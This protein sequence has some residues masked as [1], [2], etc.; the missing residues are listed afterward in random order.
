VAWQVGTGQANPLT[1]RAIAMLTSTFRY[2]ATA[3]G[4]GS[5]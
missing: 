4:C 2:L 5:A 3:D 1:W